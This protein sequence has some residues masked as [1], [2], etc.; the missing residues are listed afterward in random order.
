MNIATLA[1]ALT[2]SVVMVSWTPASTYTDGSPLPIERTWTL[3][4]QHPQSCAQTT[5]TSAPSQ[6]YGFPVSFDA[7]GLTMFTQPIGTTYCYV[8]RTV[9]W[10][11]APNG[12]A[13]SS[14]PVK[15]EKDI[16]EAPVCRSC[17]Q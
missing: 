3:V 12:L 1:A 15:I 4:E 13:V 6:G 14:D 5:I 8:A 16:T 2:W 17:H 7:G 9:V 11:Q 10:A